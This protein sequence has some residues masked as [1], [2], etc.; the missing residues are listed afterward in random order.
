MQSL[1]RPVEK[2][3]ALGR[4]WRGGYERPTLDQE[5]TR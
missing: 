4:R 3:S 2:V 1:P 5:G